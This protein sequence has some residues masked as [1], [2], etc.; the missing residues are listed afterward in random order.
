MIDLVCRR[1]YGCLR[2]FGQWPGLLGPSAPPTPLGKLEE[3]WVIANHKLV[4]FHAAFLSSLFMLTGAG[5]GTLQ[6]LQFVFSPIWHNVPPGKPGWRLG[7]EVFLSGVIW[8]LG[9]HVNI[10]IHELGH[11]IAAVKT[12]NLRPEHLEQAH[13]R[14]SGSGRWGWLLRGFLTIPWGRFPGVKKESGNFFPDVKAQN[15]AV[16][17]AGPLTSQTLMWA[18]LPLGAVLV[19]LGFGILHSAAVIWFGRL[20]FTVGVVALLDRLLADSGAVRAFRARQSG[21]AARAAEAR[22][23][24]AG[25]RWDPAPVKQMML[26]Q[27]LQEVAVGDGKVRAPW[28]YRNCLM[29]GRHTEEQGGNLSFQEFM[30]LPLSAGDYVEA[31]RMTN[32]LQT[33]VIQIVQDSEGMNFVGIGLEGGM[34]GAYSKR[35]EDAIPEERALKV[36]VQAIEECGFVPGKD[37]ALALDPAASELS[38]AFR[39]HT[40]SSDAV[41]QYFFWRAEEPRVMSSEQLVELY[42]DWV[43]KYP[44][45]SIEDGFAED[46]PEGWKMLMKELGEEIFI[47]GDDLVTT[48]DTNIIR[49]IEEGLINTVLVK[50]NQIGSLCETL[51]A[52]HA[53]KS[54]GMA[55]VVSHRSKSPNDTMEADIAFAID[56][57][58]MKCGGGSNTE[59]LIKYAR[60]VELMRSAQKGFKITRPLEGDLKIA[61]ITAREEA[62]NAGIPTVGV[63]V[64]LENGVSFHGATPLGTSAGTDEAIHLIDSTIE[65]GPATQKHAEL[66][67][68]DP[69]SK[70]HK[71]KKAVTGEA[72]RAKNDPQLSEL[73][74]RA[75]RYGGKGCLNAVDNVEKH[76]A[77][78]FLG[79]A[80]SELGGL[81]DVDAQLLALERKLAIQRGKLAQ[82]AGGEEQVAIMQRKA[83]LGM[84]AILSC[85]LALGRLIAARDGV[86][87]SDLLAR[88]EG[89][90]DRDKLYGLAGK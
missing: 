5:W 68:F 42:R 35:A 34:V 78:P 79:K 60:I 45:V 63:T 52:T 65:A 74:R 69:A 46:D 62:T 56:A 85:S 11:Y 89:K 9:W 27:R 80:L 3:G 76:I 17:A 64:R 13:A 50:A 43:A 44:I 16:S 26:A 51:L 18:A 10:A 32:A 59:R 41:G 23:A 33:R 6:V 29:G 47:I 14:L 12:N 21:A 20:F 58:G 88:L 71:F 4:S 48:K 70:T 31:Q 54:R 67:D 72:V 30:F 73:W 55:M 7:Y 82:S 24:A 90:I 53:G 36:A 49:A 84:N 39:E 37:V 87:L 40:G 38:V 25:G 15:L 86:E 22:R 1:I 2:G 77:P 81:V 75:Q 19:A 83:N 28:Q 66:F 61:D 57:V 8:Y